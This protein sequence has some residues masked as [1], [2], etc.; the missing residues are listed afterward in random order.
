MTQAYYS[1]F[2]PDITDSGAKGS[3][4]PITTTGEISDIVNA[5]DTLESKVSV[6]EEG[7]FFDTTPPAQVTGVVLTSD[8]VLDTDSSQVV[9]VKVVWN[10][11]TET[12]LNFYEIGIS[13]QGSSEIQYQVGKTSTNYIW[14]VRGGRSFSVRVRA[15]DTSGNRGA[16]SS[17]ANI[18]SAKDTTAP[19]LPTGLAIDAAINTVFLSWTNPSDPDLYS[20]EVYEAPDAT[21]TPTKIG[22]TSGQPN[23]KAS[24]TRSGLPSGVTKFYSLKAVDTSGNKSAFTSSVSATTSKINNVD[25]TPGLEVPG[26]GPSNPNPVGYNGPKLFWNTTEQRLYTYTNGHWA[27]TVTPVGN[28]L[29]VDPGFTNKAV[30]GPDGTIVIVTDGVVGNTALQL[31][32]TALNPYNYIPIDR[33]KSYRLSVW[34]RTVSGSGGIIYA[35]LD[36]HDSAGNMITPPGNPNSYFTYFVSGQS[37]TGW[38][39][40][41]AIL[42]SSSIPANASTMSPVLIGNYGNGT[43]V[44]QFQDFRIQEV[45]GT[46]LIKDGAITTDKIAVGAIQA[47]QISAGAVQAEA[48]AVGIKGRNLLYSGGAESGTTANWAL[49]SADTGTGLYT[50]AGGKSGAYSY[51]LQKIDSG[52]NIATMAKAVPVVPGTKYY[53]KLWAKQIVTLSSGGGVYLRVFGSSAP[54]IGQYVG[55]PTGEYKVVTPAGN[56]VENISLSGTDWNLLEGTWTCP[57]NVYWASVV[58][59]NWTGGSTNVI[60]DEVEFFPQVSTTTIQDGAITTEKMVVN[61]ILGDRIKANTLDATKI[62]AGSISTDR[63]SVGARDSTLRNLIQMP[64]WGSGSISSN[65]YAAD[66]N[67]SAN[68]WFV[69][70]SPSGGAEMLLKMT[71]TGSADNGGWDIVIPASAGWSPNKAYRYYTW[72]YAEPGINNAIYHGCGNVQYLAGENGG[73]D[74]SNPY[75]FSFE[76]S[77]IT[78]GKWYLM[79]GVIHPANSTISNTGVS[80]L[81]DPITGQK[82]S[83]SP[84]YRW[85][86]AAT[87]GAFRSYQYY[88]YVGGVAYFTKPVVE[89]LVS[90]Q[91]TSIR[92]LMQNIDFA[93]NINTGTTKILPGSIEVVG[94]TTLADWRHGGDLTKISGGAIAA[95]TI[96]A[97]KLTVGNRA[98]SIDQLAFQ[99]DRTTGKLTWTDGIIFWTDDTG[100]P[101]PAYISANSMSWQG[102]IINYIWWVKGNSY[103]TYA[104][105]NW[106]SIVSNPDAILICTWRN[107]ANFNANYGTTIIDGDRITTN[108]ISANKLNVGSLSAISANIG[109]LVSYNG[110]GGRVERDANGSRLYDNNGVLRMRWGFW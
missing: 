80:G 36:L 74:A 16:W 96:T 109:S 3:T 78:A 10:A 73:G 92:S 21:T 44:H 57:D 75:F 12:D 19:G 28:V 61:T 93:T 13:E 76:K 11:S 67:A 58:F 85:S 20:V 68:S 71:A 32:G 99:Y 24:F 102:G 89:E 105:D 53:V 100:T 87:S 50:V 8:I 5:V 38:T 1:S 7:G 59:Y 46:T 49:V 14:R 15:V 47:G 52:L 62:T 97:N 51:A 25:L 6:L 60:F 98:I 40:Y 54:T 31:N 70:V 77:T 56:Y 17:T 26:T 29:N 91:T 43:S 39:Y 84:E 18:T 35:G 88:G 45:V 79:V 106:A 63:L 72:V 41:E 48:L 27:N 107:G 101:Q 103:L 37:P 95:N 23:S 4:I 108:S 2:F 9:T 33:T 94:G 30:W 90:G 64:N 83:A 22:E 69:G 66:N 104:A 42:N 110:Q 65:L 34:A 86:P 81:Y 82:L 55:T